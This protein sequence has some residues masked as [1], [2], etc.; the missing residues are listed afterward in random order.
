MFLRSWIKS[1]KYLGLSLLL[2]L[3]LL[4]LS[5]W[6]SF[7]TPP[8]AV[9]E[10]VEI[11]LQPPTFAASGKPAPTLQ[12]GKGSGPSNKKT[13]SQDLVQKFLSPTVSSEGYA[14]EGRRQQEGSWD[15]GGYTQDDD[16][17]IAWGAGGGTFE[18]VQDLTLMKR[19]HEKVDALL[20]YPSILASHQVSG[21]VNTRIVFN[22]EGN[23]DWQRT[24]INAVD[25]HLRVFVLHIL[26][27]VCIENYKRYLKG[28]ISTNIDMS[29]QFS[30]SEQ[31][32]TEELIKKN[33]KILGNVL[34]FFRNSHQSVAQ[35]RLGPFTGMFPI[36]FVA[37]DF[38]W[39]MENFEKYVNEKDPM[40]EYR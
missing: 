26:K 16:S 20:F 25:P 40:D 2:H 34:F 11:E 24:K 30:I 13:S 38:P 7:K 10:I 6:P 32:T 1:I 9:P 14:H 5:L 18:R 37:L 27:K 35:W 15:E 33:Q 19:L 29:F 28:R 17:N 31:P 4:W 12:G 22:R 23:C 36:P 21:V 3:V 39:L 8:K